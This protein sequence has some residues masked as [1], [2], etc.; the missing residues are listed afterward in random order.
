MNKQNNG[1]P[2]SIRVKPDILAQL[3]TASA[4]AGVKRSEFIRAAILEK[5]QREA[6]RNGA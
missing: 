6:K 2:F 5:L 4:N 1:K 3:K